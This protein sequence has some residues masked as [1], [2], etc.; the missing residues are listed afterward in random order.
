V[1]A[2][3]ADGERTL[4]AFGGA[5]VAVVDVASGTRRE[6]TAA[7]PIDALEVS[8]P[9]A[10]WVDHQG[11]LWKLDLAGNVP[12]QVSLDETV[13]DL[14]ASPDGRWI[15]LAGQS[16]LLVLD[17][18]QSSQPATPVIS[19]DTRALAWSADS[20]DLGALVG[21][22]LIR[23]RVEG[24]P[25]VVFRRDVGQ[26]TAVAA[27]KA[28]L[29]TA[30]PTG[31]VVRPDGPVRKIPGS[32]T[33][34]LREARGGTMI[35][36][37]PHG[38][39]LA[40]S[41]DGDRPLTSPVGKLTAIAASPASPWVTAAA[42]G[43]VLMW[44]LDTIEPE[45]VAGAATGAAFVGK[46]VLVTYVDDPAQWNKRPL[47]PIA[48]LTAA[49]PAPDFDHAIVVDGTH[50]AR[51]VS[52]TGEA[53]DL[54]DDITAAA[55]VSDR[56]YLIGTGSELR[57]HDGDRETTLVR[58]GP[59]TWISVFASQ[60]AAGFGDGTVW[61]G[62]VTG[63]GDTVHVDPAS[64][65]GVIL[66]DG[67][68]RV[69]AGGELRVWKPHATALDDLGVALGTQTSLVPDLGA[70]LT[71]GGALDL[72]DGSDRWTL[73]DG[74][75]FTSVQLSSDAS[76]VLATTQDAVLE[77]TLELPATPGA[78]AQWVDGLTNARTDGGPT[79]PLSWR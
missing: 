32:F 66:A 65:A 29:Y 20:L 77:W 69:A 64:T 19:G 13:H 28:G 27:T 54:G 36:A 67:T 7:A 10:Y 58:R 18:T 40:I 33:L 63:G 49:A 1:Q 73:D 34:G 15:A 11:A 52:V 35:A 48:G 39:L 56:R 60:I 9:I 31:V 26:R 22:S 16:H 24:E 51:L 45:H 68:V 8:G 4:V 25:D 38:T 21:D 53:T 62:T 37:D 76:R 75:A 72:I 12:L 42:S 44:N 3:F 41:D 70:T 74:R 46:Q 14:A 23:V 30:G 17:R 61:R 55:Y 59:V 78:A 47:V 71:A 2:R 79:A 50:H 5:H 43:V 6:I 57:L